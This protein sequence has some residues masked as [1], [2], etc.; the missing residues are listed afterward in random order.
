MASRLADFRSRLGGLGSAETLGGIIFMR[1]WK[2]TLIEQRA[3]LGSY[4]HEFVFGDGQVS[5]VRD[6]GFRVEFCV[7]SDL[8]PGGH[9]DYPWSSF[10]REA[11]I[12][13]NPERAK[14]CGWVDQRKE[15]Q[16]LLTE[17]EEKGII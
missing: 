13:C 10:E 8:N 3:I 14:E 11:W 12:I 2:P 15:G 17:A 6:E 5:Q 16:K 1:N 7:H 9:I 4:V